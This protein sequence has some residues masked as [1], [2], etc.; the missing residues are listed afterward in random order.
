[1]KISDIDIL[2]ENDI[3][4]VIIYNEISD[5]CKLQKNNNI[6]IIN[7]KY[8]KENLGVKDKFYMCLNNFAFVLNNLKHCNFENFTNNI[9]TLNIKEKYSKLIGKIFCASHDPRTNEICLYNKNFEYIL[10]HELLHMASSKKINNELILSGLTIIDLKNRKKYGV[11][12]NEGYT[13]YI[14]LKYFNKDMDV[15]KIQVNFIKQLEKIVGE[16]LMEQMYFNADL[17]GLIN[18]LM[19]YKNTKEE[20][21]E[22]ISNLDLVHKYMNSLNLIKILKIQKLFIKATAFLVKSYYAKLMNDNLTY[23]DRIKELNK[24]MNELVDIDI[25]GFKSKYDNVEESYKYY[26]KELKK[27]FKVRKL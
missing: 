19:K 3:I 20:V 16:E 2:I 10:Y 12:L 13:E 5:V 9:K 4:P 1:M 22:F 23:K 24:Y 25:I 26:S 11:F 17:K 14:V 18:E 15:Y 7:E 6:K 21:I 27:K 8:T